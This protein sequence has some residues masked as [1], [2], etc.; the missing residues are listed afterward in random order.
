MDKTSDPKMIKRSDHVHRDCS[1][2]VGCQQLASSTF[3]ES[4]PWKILLDPNPVIR[5]FVGERER[6]MQLRDSRM[7][8]AA[9]S[10][11]LAFNSRL[12]IRP[13]RRHL[14]CVLN[15]RDFDQVSALKCPTPKWPNVIGVKRNTA[16]LCDEV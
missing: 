8:A 1:D 12:R 6:L 16:V 4:P 10:L 7:N 15:P 13:Q 9:L 11:A 2:D 5:T 3:F 14:Q